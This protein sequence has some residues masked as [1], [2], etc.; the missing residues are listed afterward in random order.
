M[1]DIAALSP[2]AQR[3]RQQRIATLWSTQ[4]GASLSEVEAAVDQDIAQEEAAQAEGQRRAD[5]F[6]DSF[7]RMTSCPVCGASAIGE[8]VCT[9][10]RPVVAQLRAERLGT[11]IV[12]GLGRSRRELAELYLDRT[13]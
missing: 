12:E 13:T 3:E 2:T 7:A 6:A 10:C 8:G 5:S 1:T 4:P 11:E 9:N